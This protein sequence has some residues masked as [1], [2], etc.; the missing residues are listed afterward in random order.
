MLKFRFSLPS[1]FISLALFALLLFI[2]IYVRDSF[3]RPFLGDV[4][5]VIWL[6]FSFKSWLDVKP[7]TLSLFVLFIAFLLEFFQ[8]IH[9]V[10][11]LG[12]SHITVIR[13]VLGSTY[14]P[15]DLLAYSLGWSTILVIEMMSRKGQR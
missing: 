7:L 6:Y 10:D 15:H 2:A 4:I 1:L 14:D 8:Y 12:L 11:I 3:V 13:I 9:I 5:A